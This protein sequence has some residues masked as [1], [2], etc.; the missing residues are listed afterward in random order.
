VYLTKDDKALLTGCYNRVVER[1]HGMIKKIEPDYRKLFLDERR[2][3]GVKQDNTI[4]GYMNF[5]YQTEYPYKNHILI[6]EFVY[7]TKEALLKLCTF[8]HTQADQ[9][10]RIIVNTQDETFHYLVVNPA[11]GQFEAFSSEQKEMS[12]C[13]V[14]MMYRVVN[15]RRMFET[16]HKHN[17]GNQTCKLKITIKDDFLESNNGSLIVHF[18]NGIP[19]LQEQDYEVEILLNI[20]EFSSFFMGAVSFKTL[21]RYG[22]AEISDLEYTDC[23]NTVFMTEQKPMSTTYF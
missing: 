5:S 22:L 23:V 10:E 19:T 9:F 7:E 2:I 8:L 6:H 13:A 20:S 17:F 16:L 3:V 11:N 1:T 12:A 4:S 21:L 18:E 15:V 14:G